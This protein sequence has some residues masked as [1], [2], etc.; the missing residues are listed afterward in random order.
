MRE[1]GASAE[2][3]LSYDRRSLTIWVALLA[4]AQMAGVITTRPIP[5]EGGVEAN[6]TAAFVMQVG[7]VG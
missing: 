2:P 5:S 7:G 3:G 6:Q 1:S 4:R